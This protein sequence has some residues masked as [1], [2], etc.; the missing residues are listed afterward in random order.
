[1]KDGSWD[2]WAPEPGDQFIVKAQKPFSANDVLTFSATGG[3]ID[4]GAPASLLEDI[5]VV[6][7]PYVVTASWEPQ[8]LYDSGRGVRKIDFIHLPPECTISIY[9]M[10]GKF[11]Q[12]IEHNSEI[13]DGAESWNLLSRDGLEVSYGVYLYHVDAP[14]IGNH[15]SKFAVIK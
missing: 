12:S 6:P 14:G 8:H 10:S 5:S 4:V 15:V 3:D 13:W 1:L 7:N 2:N 9:T 11:V